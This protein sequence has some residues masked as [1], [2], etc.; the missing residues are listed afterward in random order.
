MYSRLVGVGGYLPKT[1]LSNQDLANKYQLDTSD[2]WIVA[3][4]GINK[5]HICVENENSLS[6]AYEASRIAIASAEISV[7][8]IDLVVYATCTPAKS[9]PSDATQLQSM[10]GLKKGV[11]AFDLNAACSGFVYAAVVADQFIK[12]QGATCVLVVGSD[13]MTS[14]LDWQDRSTCVLFGD[15]AGAVILK[16]DTYPGIL[17][18]TIGADGSKLEL[19]HTNNINN[20][21]SIH[22]Q[23]QGVFKNAVKTLESLVDQVLSPVGLEHADVNWL[24]AHQANIRIINCTAKLLNLPDAKVVKTVAKHANTSAAS[25][26]LALFELMNSGQVKSGENILMEAFGA[27]FSWGALLLKYL[28]KYGKKNSCSDWC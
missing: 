19:L 5:R 2:E 23:G 22:M 9:M 11:P 14:L 27:G 28:G 18:S 3:R 6:M 26:P 10:L 15:G 12:S 7:E 8:D 16:S 1:H 4:T 25:I 21:N 24:V 13:H 20:K 17:S